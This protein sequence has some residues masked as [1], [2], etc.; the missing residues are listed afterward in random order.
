[1]SNLDH[2]DI[3]IGL[4]AACRNAETIPSQRGVTFYLCRLS[5]SDRRYPK[6]PTLP[7]IAC[8]GYRQLHEP[9]QWAQ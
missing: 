9:G 5:F 2:A 6:Y 7:V 8:E 1:M 3:H 4:C